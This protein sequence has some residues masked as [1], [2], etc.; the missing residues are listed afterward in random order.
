[1]A[2]ASVAVDFNQTLDV[3]RGSSSEVTLNGNIVRD[4]V[5]DFSDIGFAQISAAGVGINTGCF[6]NFGGGSSADTVNIGKADFYTL[7][8]R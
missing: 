4:E 1:V 3:H 6:D 8:I 7:V 2:D 5:A